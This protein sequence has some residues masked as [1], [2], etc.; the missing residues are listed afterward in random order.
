MKILYISALASEARIDMEYRRTGLNPGFAVQ[1]FSRLL[2]KGLVDNGTDVIALSNPP[3]V[4]GKKRFVHSFR[5]QEHGVTY[6]Y[7]PYINLPILKHLCLFL[8]S[9]F[10]VLIW[11]VHNRK[12]KTVICDVLAV[13]IC[14]GALL[15]TKINRL[16]SVAVVTDIYSQMVG[17]RHSG[18]DAIIRSFAGQLQKWYSTSFSHYVLLTESMNS[19]VNPHH[20]PYIVMEALCAETGVNDCDNSTEKDTPQTVLYA[21]GIEKKYGLENLVKA[22]QKLSIN[23]IRLVVYGNGTYVDGLKK[24]CSQDNRIQYK[25]VVTNEDIIK[26]EHRATLLVNPRFSTEEFAKYSF[27][28]KNMEYMV[29]GTPL[30]TTKL[31]G[32][33]SEYYPYVY[34]FDHGETVDGFAQVL[35]DVLS[36]SHEKLTQKGKD[37]KDFVLRVK[38]NIVQT[39]RIIQLINT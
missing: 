3:Y 10:Y 24:I 28:S 13:S 20:K 18:F 14:F 12:N 16:K 4:N 11:G 2:V 22:F 37:G 23:N 29:S 34:L 21:G 39:Q 7:V 31:P 27:P 32:M 38:N 35:N 15:S 26:A 6:K 19:M 25:G 1:K 8:Y 5:E 33:P 17:K 30:L 36:L 9:F